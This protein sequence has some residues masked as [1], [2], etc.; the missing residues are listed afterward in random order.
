MFQVAREIHFCYGHRILSDP[1]GRCQHLH[2]HTARALVVL[3]SPSLDDRGMVLDFSDIRQHVAGWVDQHFDHCMILQQND[4]LVTELQAA[5]EPLFLTE[6]PPTARE[7]ARIIFQF[8]QECGFPV[9]HVEFWETDDVVDR[10]P[11]PYPA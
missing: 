9:V 5:G 2:G 10:Y 1:T 6:A 11:Q 4:P 8:A 3:E 7:L